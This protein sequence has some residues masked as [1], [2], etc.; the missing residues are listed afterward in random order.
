M[1]G[2]SLLGQPD[3]T[4]RA[5]QQAHSELLFESSDCL[6]DRGGGQAEHAP[7]GDEAAEIGGAHEGGQST[8]AIHC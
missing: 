8:Q 5:L 3:T 1:K 6:A 7:G 4:G 2:A